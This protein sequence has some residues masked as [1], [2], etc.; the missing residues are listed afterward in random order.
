MTVK[1][2]RD[3]ARKFYHK[4]SKIEMKGNFKQISVGI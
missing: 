2:A 1:E 4:I 3:I